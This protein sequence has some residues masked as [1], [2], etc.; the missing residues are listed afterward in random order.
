MN[1]FGLRDE[2]N[3]FV[4]LVFLGA[5]LMPLIFNIYGL[6]PYELPK[7]ALLY[8]LATATLFLLTRQVWK[9]Q[10]LAWN[11]PAVYAYV[12][13]L[14]LYMV[15]SINAESW[16]YAV[17]GTR[18]IESLIFF[19]AGF[20]LVLL[21]LQIKQ[22]KMIFVSKIFIWQSLFI[23][24][25]A[26]V[27]TFLKIATYDYLR[28]VLIRATSTLGSAAFLSYYLNFVFFFLVYLFL[29]ERR[30]KFKVAYGTIIFIN[31]WALVMTGARAAWIALF[32]AMLVLVLKVFRDR[33]KLLVSGVLLGLFIALLVPFIQL[34]RSDRP[35]SIF[36][37]TDYNV[38]SRTNVWQMSIGLI[39]Q[40][41]FFGV[42]PNNFEL[43]YQQLRNQ[44]LAKGYGYFDQAHNFIL[45]MLLNVGIVGFV[46]L[47]AFFCFV[48]RSAY[49]V[50]FNEPFGFDFVVLLGLGTIFIQA[51]L[52]PLDITS[53][54][55]ILIFSGYLLGRG[56]KEVVPNKR[57]AYGA[58]V[59]AIAMLI[60][61]L[62]FFGSQT[63]FYQGM[64][65]YYRMDY[66]KT[67]KAADIASKIYP[68]EVNYTIYRAAA[69]AKGEN[70]MD[71]GLARLDK[72]HAGQI[73]HKARAASIWLYLAHQN[74]DRAMQERGLSMFREALAVDRN[75]L[76]MMSDYAAWN[77]ALGN[78]PEAEKYLLQIIELDPKSSQA[79]ILLAGTYG[80]QG[81]I[82]RQNETLHALYDLDPTNM[83]LKKFLIDIEKGEIKPV[84]DVKVQVNIA[85]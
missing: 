53:W 26:L 23:S 84:Y 21:G 6:Q 76:R 34:S 40:N 10:P 51:M 63:I 7:I 35:V 67:A 56:G 24:I 32:I 75:N 22:E 65:A 85:E 8:F 68:F 16:H 61:A 57:W 20:P 38:Y 13:F 55:F 82:Q 64:R 28:P 54:F 2:K 9:G 81:D 83:E 50:V 42:G 30:F 27:Q 45:Q 48:F 69:I 66:S 5:F 80:K 4:K 47:L 1:L 62:A 19:L 78:Y 46:L 79:M 77:Y 52:Q 41:P 72:L 31:L 74:N 43:H 71:P 29:Q 18:H 17:F 44:E 39:K 15:L 12:A 25:L 59:S 33:K 37:G 49:R 14:L 70:R 58:G 73:R 60:Y 3:H 36:S 11:K